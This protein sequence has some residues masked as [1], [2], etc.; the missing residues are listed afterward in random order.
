MSAA[1]GSRRR[2]EAKPF[3][4]PFSHKGRREAGRFAWLCASRPC[5]G[6]TA[7]SSQ[8]FDLG[9]APVQSESNPARGWMRIGLVA[10]R[11]LGPNQQEGSAMFR[12]VLPVLAALVLVTA[13]LIPDDAFARRGGGGYR[14][15][16]GFHGG[17]VRAGGVYR[18][19]AVRAGRVGRVGYAGYRGGYYPRRGYGAAAV[20]AAAVGAAAY[21][22]Y[23]SYNNCYDAYG[24]YICGGQYRY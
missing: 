20:G 14:G 2:C 16:G 4:L 8:S 22:A 11:T 3:L 19:G 10:A 15:G 1:T 6:G 7:S 24:N 21:G 17:A 9:Q 5:Q 13:S 12:Y 18:G 23:G